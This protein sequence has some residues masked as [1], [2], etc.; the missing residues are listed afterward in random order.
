[1]A[2]GD[3]QDPRSLVVTVTRRH[4]TSMGIFADAGRLPA[5]N[6]AAGGK[7]HVVTSDVVTSDVVTSDVVRTVAVMTDTTTSETRDAVGIV[8]KARR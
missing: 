3:A 4:A 6:M 8:V 5:R 7:N 1:M 2:G